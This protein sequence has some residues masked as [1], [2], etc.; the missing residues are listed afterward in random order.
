MRRTVNNLI[1]YFGNYGRDQNSID[2]GRARVIAALEVEA[3]ER[4]RLPDLIMQNAEVLYPYHEQLSSHLCE[5]VR[6]TERPHSFTSIYRVVR[7]SA[8]VINWC[9]RSLQ[10]AQRNSQDESLWYCKLILGRLQE[11]VR[12]S[13]LQHSD[14]IA[15]SDYEQLLTETFKIMKKIFL[16]HPVGALGAPREDEPGPALESRDVPLS[17]RL[18]ELNASYLM[19][20]YGRVED[21]RVLQHVLAALG[22]VR[23]G[24]AKCILL[25][26]KLLKMLITKL[27]ARPQANKDKISEVIRRLEDFVG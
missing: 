21:Q 12:Q 19:V 17:L 26:L 10:E 9:Q 13:S 15:S 4:H 2:V 18:F 3:Q 27:M 8:T 11:L 25:G 7:A 20:N 6:T 14:S 24:D 5:L 23:S 16:V 22:H 1:Q